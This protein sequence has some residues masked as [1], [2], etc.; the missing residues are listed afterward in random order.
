[1]K[2]N[3]HNYE[4]VFLD[5]YEGNLSAEDVSELLLFLENHPEL[6]EDFESFENIVLVLSPFM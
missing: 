5:Y 3:L 1:M 2:I 6:K 4:A